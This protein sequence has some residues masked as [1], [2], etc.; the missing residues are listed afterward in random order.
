MLG[1]ARYGVFR[2]V[3]R[4]RG[5]GDR[6]FQRYGDLCGQ[7]HRLPALE[8]RPAGQGLL[9]PSLDALPERARAVGDHGPA[10][11]RGRSNLWQRLL[12]LQRDR[13]AA[14]L[15]TGRRGGRLA[16]PGLRRAG[17]AFDPF[18]LRDGGAHAAHLRRARNPTVRRRPGPGVRGGFRAQG[19]GSQGRRSDRQVDREGARGG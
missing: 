16:R 17:E 9:L 1:D 13:L 6:A 19:A 3:G 14:V 4:R 5:Q 7:G 8:V 12:G 15:L 2:V 11:R 10:F 18:L